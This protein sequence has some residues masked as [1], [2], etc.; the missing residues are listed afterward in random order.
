MVQLSQQRTPPTSPASGRWWI[1]LLT[2]ALFAFHV[3]YVRIHLLTEA[4]YNGASTTVEHSAHYHDD[5]EGDSDHH[6]DHDQHQP[7][8]A[9]DHQLQPANKQQ[10]CFATVVFLL[11]ATS[12]LSTPSELFVVYLTFE[13]GSRP[14]ESPPDPAQPRAPPTV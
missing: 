14:G 11:P 6:H 1:G 3:N 2:A 9:S 12:L 5:H 8:S 10:S 13:R 4:H 7:H